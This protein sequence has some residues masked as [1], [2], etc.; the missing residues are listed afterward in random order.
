[1]ALMSAHTHDDVNWAAKLPSMRRADALS[2]GALAEVADRLTRDLPDQATVVD[3]GSGSGGMSGALAA[4]LARQGGGTL[5]LLDAVEE[6]LSAASEAARAASADAVS[7]PG[8]DASGAAQVQVGTVV[9]DAA[10][11]DLPALLPPADLVWASAVVHHLP[12]QQ[13]AVDRLS[14]VLRPGGLLAVAEGGL[15]TRC[16]PWDLGVGE[17][18]LEARLNSAR[19]AWFG[20]LRAGMEGAVQMP[21]G[22]GTALANAGLSN[23]TSFSYLVDHPAPAPAPVTEF[24]ADR[25]A[26]LAQVADDR[27]T[28]TDRRTARSLVDPDAPEYLGNRS[29]VFLL[30]CYTVHCG[31]SR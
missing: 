9:A 30:S 16:L 11:P 10:E 18:G 29:D 19:D 23:V 3:I 21:Y 7:A 4:S 28:D 26:W 17:P 20:E 22:W 25:V 31:W 12:D 5:V 2:G 1:M 24:A 14:A 13:A 6:L 15:E 27:L 8:A